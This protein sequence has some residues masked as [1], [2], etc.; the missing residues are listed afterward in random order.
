M[1]FND[2]EKENS[3]D[4]TIN[5]EDYEHTIISLRDMYP[6]ILGWELSVDVEETT[7]LD[8]KDRII[9]HVNVKKRVTTN[10]DDYES[11]RGTR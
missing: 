9:L 11:S 1:E 4:K 10:T 8:G 2:Y 3:F 7:P 6:S 5:K